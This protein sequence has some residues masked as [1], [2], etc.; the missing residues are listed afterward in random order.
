MI[1]RVFCALIAS[2]MMICTSSFVFAEDVDSNMPDGIPSLDPFYTNDYTVLPNEIG[3]RADYITVQTCSIGSNSVGKVT[4]T[5][6]FSTN[7][8]MQKLGFTTLRVQHWNGSS[9]EDVW[10]KTDQY[11]Y[12]TDYFAYVKTLSNM[13]SNDYYRLSVDLYAKKGFLLV[14]TKTLVTDYIRCK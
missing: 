14:Q 12:N 3:D 7:A 8:T 4:V 10:T 6:S 13:A 9:W 1:K 5:V 2:I 11:V